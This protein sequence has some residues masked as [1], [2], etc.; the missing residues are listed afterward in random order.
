MNISQ[1]SSISDLNFL[2]QINLSCTNCSSFIGSKQ[3]EL[4][5][6]LRAVTTTLFNSIETH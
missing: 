6:P 1:G 4:D 2:D 5:N 3:N